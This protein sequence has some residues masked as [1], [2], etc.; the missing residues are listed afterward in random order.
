MKTYVYMD[1]NGVLYTSL[2]LLNGRPIIWNEHQK[3]VG[4]LH[5][6]KIMYFMGEL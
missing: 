5:E 3:Y 4:F 1:E 2:M 6:T